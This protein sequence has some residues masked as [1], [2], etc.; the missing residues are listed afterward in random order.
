[1]YPQGISND[2]TVVIGTASGSSVNLQMFRWTRPGGFVSLP[3]YNGA[4]DCNVTA[5]SGNGTYEVGYCASGTTPV[6]WMGTNA[7]ALLGAVF[8]LNIPNCANFDGSVISGVVIGNGTFPGWWRVGSPASYLMNLPANTSGASAG[9]INADGSVIVGTL[10]NSAIVNRQAFY[11]TL[12]SGQVKLIPLP[13]GAGSSTGGYVSGDGTKI[14]FSGNNG[15][16]IYTPSNGAMTK[17][18]YPGDDY[19]NAFALSSDGTTAGGNGPSGV[20]LSTNGATPK[21]LGSI[22]ATL[23]VDVGGF[24]FDDIYGISSN[25]KVIIGAGALVAGSHDEGWIVVLP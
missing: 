19:E 5:I 11:W 12:A 7:P 16:F 9:S 1:V 25:G 23:G 18:L 8:T 4:T 10:D 3:G 24:L 14:L 6:R 20:W 13:P 17:L 2:G 22:L 15:A 21:L